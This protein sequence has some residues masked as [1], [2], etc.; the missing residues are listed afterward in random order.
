RGSARWG[1]HHLA[2]TIASLP[3][4]GMVPEGHG[5]SDPP[6]TLPYTI[7]RIL[8]VMIHKGDTDLAYEISPLY[9]ESLYGNFTPLLH[10]F[11]RA[12][13]PRHRAPRY[14]PRRKPWTA[15]APATVEASESSRTGEGH[16]ER[17]KE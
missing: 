15:A 9:R 4:C 11:Y 5:A 16:H 6:N 17:D 1:T 3:G 10:H 14:T 13:M 8:Q 2:E 12:F 7:A